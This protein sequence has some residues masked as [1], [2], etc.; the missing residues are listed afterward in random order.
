MVAVVR[1]KAWSGNGSSGVRTMRWLV[2]LEWEMTRMLR[3]GMWQPMQLSL[4][5]VAWRAAC[6]AVQL[7]SPWQARHL[8]LK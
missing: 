2:A 6:G 4:G 8:D 1:L 3:W 5:V 7:A